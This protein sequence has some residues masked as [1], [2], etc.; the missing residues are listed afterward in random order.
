MRNV[1]VDVGPGEMVVEVVQL[2]HQA[3]AR[4]GEKADASGGDAS[5]HDLA[6]GVQLARGQAARLLVEGQV[7][8]ERPQVGEPS[9]LELLTAA[10]GFTRLRLSPD[11]SQAELVVELCALIGQARALDC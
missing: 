7:I 11:F 5:L 4:A 10:E 3:A 1:S 2:L 9:V 8:S 6:L